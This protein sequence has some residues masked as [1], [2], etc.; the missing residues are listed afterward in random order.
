MNSKRNKKNDNSTN[1]STSKVS[2]SD[3]TK[4]I[5]TIICLASI[6]LIP[7]GLAV[8]WTST[9]WKTKLKV[10]LSAVLGP[11]YIAGILFMLL[12]EPSNNKNGLPLPIQYS[13]GQSQTDSL[14][15]TKGESL[16]LP[17]NDNN[18]SRKKAKDKKKQS[19]PDEEQLPLS[20]KR[21]KNGKS[22]RLFY[23]ILFFLFM[24]FLIIWQNI[25]NNKKPRYENPYVDTDKYKLPLADNAKI[26]MVHFLKLRLNKDEK[27]I[28]ATETNQKDNEG[29]LIVTNQRVVIMDKTQN[30][31]FPLGVLT[32]VSSV[33]D[34]VMLLTSGERKYYIFM[35]ESQL[36]YALATIRWSYKQADLNGMLK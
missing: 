31:D 26:P 16:E 12:F 7:I 34:T 8:M 17:E 5:I 22:G 27:I 32:A 4:S 28:F 10:I 20:L 23:S 29:D 36:K 30:V 2:I 9:K 14:I 24:L 25:R 33:T 1:S 18:N 19:E 3:K 15:T 35:P 13:E 11:L 21:N 6:I